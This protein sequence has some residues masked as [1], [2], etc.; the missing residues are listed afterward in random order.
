LWIAPFYLHDKILASI[1]GVAKA[2]KQGQYARIVIK[3]NALTDER[4]AKALVDAAQAGANIDV[5]VRGACILPAQ[6]PGLTENIKIRSIIGRFL[7]HSRVF[8]FGKGTEES[9]Y[10]SSADWMNRNMM[11]RIEI[12]WPIEDPVLKQRII[13]E[14]LL[15][16]EYDTQDAW[17]LN[18][19]GRYV[20][21]SDLQN[22]PTHSAQNALMLRYKEKKQ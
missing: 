9:L 20:K 6:V 1:A 7:E 18:S 13:D 14:C 19:E 21:V 2:A 17:Q 16:Y 22:G 12:A 11:R 15:A 10:L 5:I 4:L 8:Y 3:M